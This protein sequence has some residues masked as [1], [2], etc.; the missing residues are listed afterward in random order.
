MSLNEINKNEIFRETLQDALKYKLQPYYHL[1]A[2]TPIPDL[3]EKLR[4]IWKKIAVPTTNTKDPN[5]PSEPIILNTT[6]QPI[7]PN[8]IKETSHSITPSPPPQ[9]N[10]RESLMHEIKAIHKQI[11]RIHQLQSTQ[12]QQRPQKKPE[13]RACFRCGKIGHVAKFCRSKPQQPPPNRQNRFPPRGNTQRQQFMSRSNQLRRPFQQIQDNTYPNRNGAFRS[14]DNRQRRNYNNYDRQQTYNNNY[15]QQRFNRQLNNRF[16]ANPRNP[17]SR[18]QSPSHN[19]TCPDQT[20]NGQIPHE[21][22]KPITIVD[23]HNMQRT[24][25]NQTFRHPNAGTPKLNDH[26]FRTI[27]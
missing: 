4:F 16:N 15:R 12:D 23:L 26:P 25:L 24:T 9:N 6:T 5:P 7:P 14:N 21:T 1:V 13:T 18:D 2:N 8:E 3:P 27:E 11:G 22:P 10:M 20:N 19:S 17:N